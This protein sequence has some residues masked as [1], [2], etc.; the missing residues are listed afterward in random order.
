MNI[1]ITGAGLMG[2]WHSR[3][4]SKLGANITGLVDIDKTAASKLSA[5]YPDAACFTSLDDLFSAQTPDVVHI[6]TPLP[7]HS[8]LCLAAIDHGAHVV[9]EK[10]LATS[11]DEV[12]LLHEHA[13]KAGK[14]I[15]PVHQF[16]TQRGVLTA[17]R[18]LEDLGMIS[19]I[20]F[21]ICSAGAD[22]LN[23]A[24]RD[25]VVA[26]IL[27]HP[28]SVISSLWPGTDIKALEW[29]YLRTAA[30]EM[31]AHCLL[32]QIPVSLAISMSGRP[33]RCYMEIQGSRGSI[34]IDFFHGFCIQFPGR[35]SRFR[36]II[37][38]FADSA[39]LFSAAALNLARRAWRREP[40]YPGLEQLLREFYTAI[41][42]GTEGP[43]PMNVSLAVAMARDRFLQ[44]MESVS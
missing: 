11:A 25:A 3:V 5:R 18:L 32:E 24:D 22:G 15:C 36:K 8:A 26:D 17:R 28:L 12:R 14:R 13:R 38:P 35:V 33:T 40:A 37:Y 1:A 4:A 41:E 43:V 9:C 39:R 19:R 30:G 7:S 42:E 2:K 29:Q 16:A 34:L 27:P 31:L 10:P 6:C 44:G 23:P 20:S 21:V